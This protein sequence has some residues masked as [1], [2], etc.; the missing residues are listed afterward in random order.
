MKLQSPECERRW[1]AEF[2]VIADGEESYP[3]TNK[4][5]EL[6]ACT[7]DASMMSGFQNIA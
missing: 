1:M 3:G 2:I 5:E 6:F 7:G 4:T